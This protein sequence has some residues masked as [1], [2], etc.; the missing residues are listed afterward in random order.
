LMDIAMPIV[1]GLSATK[2]IIE[3]ENINSLAHTPIIALTANA[4]KGDKERF[5]SIGMDE[6]ISK[7][8]KENTILDMLKK[9]SINPNEVYEN[10]PIKKDEIIHLIP[11]KNLATLP[12]DNNTKD[13]LIYKKSAVETKIFEKV[14]SSVYDKID[15]ANS[16]KDF[17]EKIQNSTYKAILVDHETHGLDI[18]RIIKN[19]DSLSDSALILFRNF[20]T[21]VSDKLRVVF[22]EVIINSVERNYLKL[23]L[24]N[25][26]KEEE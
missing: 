11:N 25:Y 4:L 1:D 19:R 15:I 22:D 17:F 6:Y 20:E 14:L 10:Q 2:K 26:I 5:L 23:I 16:N 3:Y 21:R 8:V 9:F 24:D 13:L 18:D 12:Q 7:P